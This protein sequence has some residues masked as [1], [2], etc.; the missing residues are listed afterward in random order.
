MSIGYKV[1][2][3]EQ[4]KEARYLKQIHLYE[5]SVVNCPMNPLAEIESVKSFDPDQLD[6][7]G[8]A[9]EEL[10]EVTREMRT[11]A[12]RVRGR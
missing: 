5:V 3:K 6:V 10:E 7:V 8:R 9:V 1:I 2:E 4:R 12:R 11:L